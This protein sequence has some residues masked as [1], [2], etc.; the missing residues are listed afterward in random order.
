ME[1][2]M[3]AWTEQAACKGKTNLFFPEQGDSKSFR[4]AVAICETC[5]VIEPCRQHILEHEE[6]YGIWAGTNSVR[7]RI[8]RNPD[9][10]AAWTICGT[11]KRYLYGCRCDLCKQAG[12][13]YQ[14][15]MRAARV[16]AVTADTHTGDRHERETAQ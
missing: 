13:E 10:K 5:P 16:A 3:G 2:I 8:I 11:S 9:S 6:R 7:R 12:T 1:T 4:E 14:Q 15:K